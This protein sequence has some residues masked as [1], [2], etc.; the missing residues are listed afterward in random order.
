MSKTKS[1][2][3][4][5]T[6]SSSTS[7]TSG[8]KSRTKP[9][10]SK[11][12]YKSPKSSSV[13]SPSKGGGTSRVKSQVSN[14]VSKSRKISNKAG[15]SKTYVT[16]KGKHRVDKGAKTGIMGGLRSMFSRSS[17]GVYAGRS[18]R[19]G[20]YLTGLIFIAV[21]V[22]ILLIILFAFVFN[23]KPGDE[24]AALVTET[25]ATT[26][27]S[28]QAVVDDSTTDQED[29]LADN[30]AMPIEPEKRNGMYS[31]PPAMQIDPNKIYLAT[32]TTEKGEIVIELFADKVPNTVNNFV[33]LARDGYY[34]N[35]TFHRVLADFMAQGGDPAGS[36]M[37]SP[38]YTFADEFHA[39]LSHDTAGVLSMANSGANTNGSQFF[40]TFAPTPWLDG[41]HTV[42]G[43]VVKGMDRLQSITLRD[44]QSATE[45]GD[46]IESIT[47]TESEVSLLPTPTPL[48]YVQPGEIPVP[49]EPAQRDGLY[50]GNVPAMVIDPAKSYTAIMETEKGDITL[51]LFA[52]LVPNTVNNFVFLAREGYYDNTT[53]HRVIEG[54]MAQAG[55][56]TSFGSGGPGYAF[57][58]EINGELRHNDAGILSMANA[59][60]NTNGSQFFITFAE[61]PW[62][63]GIHTVFGKVI[64]GF[65]VL[66]SISVRDPQTASKPGDMIKTIKIVEE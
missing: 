57:A 7:R 38:G 39:D 40:I 16:G 18:T 3:T 5:R 19:S 51:E 45:P 9:T 31:S 44:P 41:V 56:P 42:F 30:G 12:S 10:R 8:A 55:D 59:G 48:V 4:S 34:D 25:Q 63:D 14:S 62:L 35:T 53:F 23:R 20:S 60:A 47:I 28:T 13:S 11:T 65:E 50:A 66:E 1:T 64:K 26:T 24:T 17:G 2:K 54:F 27:A 46:T 36:G 49:E 29:T 15:S 6:T 52:K 43:K 32:F 33:A 37:G 58:D 21:I 61:T 22:I